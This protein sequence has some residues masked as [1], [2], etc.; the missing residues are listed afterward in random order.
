MKTVPLE[1][2]KIMECLERKRA[3]A[4]RWLAGSVIPILIFLMLGACASDPE[5]KDPQTQENGPALYTAYNIWYEK[6]GNLYVIN[7]KRGAILPAGTP[8]SNLKVTRSVIRFMA[9]G[10]EFYIAFQH[11][12]HPGQSTE[13]YRE[14]MFTSKTF[15]EL[16]NGMSKEV[17][18]GIKRGAPIAGMTKQEVLIAYGYPPEHRTPTL[19]SNRWVYWRNRMGTKVIC[20]D[21]NELGTRRCR[22][23]DD[24]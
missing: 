24:L 8:I 15:E 13:S 4:A 16:T 2:E 11:R 19:E 5:G 10:V 20:F 14:K 9:N 3:G 21:E 1:W 23:P 6:P 17:I 7:Y 22:R 18:S 12:F